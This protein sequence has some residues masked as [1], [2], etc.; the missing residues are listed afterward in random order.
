ME[1]DDPKWASRAGHKLAAALEALPV[2]VT[3]KRALDVGSSTGGFTDVLLHHGATAVTALDVGYGQLLWRLRRDPRVSVVDRTNFRYVHPEAI[4]A[5]FDVVTV[6]VSFIS[7]VLLAERLAACGRA[8][9]DY[10]VL[11]KPQFEAGKGRVGRGG[12][13]T[14]PTVHAEAIERV[15]SALAGADIGPVAVLASPITGATGNREFFLH[16]RRGESGTLATA[17]VEEVV[18]R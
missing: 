16:A 12:L 6:D 3:G 7:V 5:P 8:G 4:G 15:A 18:A 11:V 1:G 9:T 13:V 17:A 14:D 10:L 2:R